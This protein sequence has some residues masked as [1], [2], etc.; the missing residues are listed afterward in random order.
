MDIR[1]SWGSWK[2]CGKL[3]QGGFGAVIHWR[4]EIS[5]R[6][7]ATKHIQDVDSLSADQKIKIKERWL[8]ELN[9]TRE[10]QDLSN[11]VAGVLLD[12]EDPGFL[13][14]L[15]GIGKLPVIV[16]EYC[17]GG[18]VRKKLNKPENVNGLVEFEVR[19]ILRSMRVAL[20]FLH[21]KCL[22]CHRDLKPDNIVIQKTG[23]G[24]I[25]YKLTD[26][27]L[28][29]PAPDKTMLQ[30]VVGTRHYF[31]PEVVE[32]GVYNMAVDYWSLGIIGYE[33]ATGEL[34]FIPHQSPKNIL[35]NLI[36]K[37]SDCIAIT[38]DIM[39]SSRFVNQKQLPVQHHLTEPFAV[40]LTKW[41]RIALDKDYKRRGQMATD[42]VQQ[43]VPVVF[44]SLDKLLQIKV[45]TIFAMN[46]CKRLAY[47]I[48]EQT[49]MVD[50]ILK[51]ERD[52]GISRNELYVV[53]PT[54]HPVKHMTPGT[55]PIDLYVAEWCDTSKESRKRNTPPVMLY[56]FKIN[57][58]SV[59]N[60]SEPIVSPLMQKCM[61]KK[62]DS[63]ERWV[64]RRLAKDFH[65]TI[66]HEQ[67]VLETFLRGLY[68]HALS[69]EDEILSNPCSDSI[70]DEIIVT[71]HAYNQIQKLRTHVQN[72]LI[73]KLEDVAEWEKLSEAY[74]VI[75]DSAESIKGNSQ[76]AL[77]QARNK[78]KETKELLKEYS[79]KDVFNVSRFSR[80]Y[81]QNG[82][83]LNDF[84]NNTMGFANNRSKFYDEGSVLSYSQNIDKLHFFFKRNQ[85]TVPIAKKKFEDIQNDIFKMHVNMLRSASENGRAPMQQLTD[86]MGE[87]S[88]SSQGPTSLPYDASTLILID[89][90]HQI[91]N[92]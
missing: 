88:M 52:T 81:L 32:S 89:K 68:E 87:M 72:E 64:P 45:L 61:S 27:G 80:N 2:F 40:E 91:M 82:I 6:E 86:A 28:A 63:K 92:T 69:L 1:R 33:L 60:V 13:D 43:E 8:K 20:H 50:L 12:K 37:P 42:E 71:T 48:T 62:V 39:D 23:N 14:Y 36:N 30:S 49:T 41:L 53:L 83:S 54:S 9:W 11:I 58:S 73:T 24:K 25:V 79:E 65:Y 59:Y 70:M 44:A 78:V 66:S 19:E 26:F 90:A 18:D 29:R 55:R 51:I 21:S 16:L 85:K 3:G 84:R 10:F 22:V 7:I 74:R 5:G 77:R 57:E 76:S 47:E 34:P 31:A 38:E 75:T 35:I 46:C 4:H 17:N 67:E 15:N 56:V